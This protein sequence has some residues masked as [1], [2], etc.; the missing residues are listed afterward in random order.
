MPKKPFKRRALTVSLATFNNACDEK[1][2][3]NAQHER[4]Q[5]YAYVFEEKKRADEAK[6]RAEDNCSPSPRI[7]RVYKRNHFWDHSAPSYHSQYVMGRPNKTCGKNHHL[8][9]C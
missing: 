7:V 9:W 4:A 5:R 1:H 3:E 2:A 8:V 6:K